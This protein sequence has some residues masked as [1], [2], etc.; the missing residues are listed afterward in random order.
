MTTALPL[1]FAV[2]LQSI[3]EPP[4]AEAT[5]AFRE[6]RYKQAD[7]LMS[8][9]V[10]E[11][12]KAYGQDSPELLPSLSFLGRIRM[13]MGETMRAEL[14]MLRVIAIREK[15]HGPGHP[16]LAPDL[17]ALG[18]FQSTQKRFHAAEPRLARAVEILE[19]FYHALDK[20]L[21]PALD[22]LAIVKI[23]LKYL[24]GAE[25]LLRRAL[26]IRETEFGPHS[27]EVAP[28]LDQLAT[29]LFRLKRY[30]ESEAASE[31][32]LA[33]WIT[34]V[35][36]EHA[37]VAISYDNLAVA[38]AAQQRYEE[39]E[40]NYSRA[41]EIRQEGA[42]RNAHALGLVMAAQGKLNEVEAL[43]ASTLGI[44]DRLP[45]GSPV[46]EVALRAYA[47]ILRKLNKDS[48]AAR[49][50]RRFEP[51]IAWN[52]EGGSLA[53]TEKISNTHFRCHLAGE[54]DQDKRNRQ[55]SWY[56]FRLDHAAGKDTT[57]DLVGLLGEYNYKPNRGAVTRDT[58]P[59]FSYDRVNW[60]HFPATAVEYDEKIP[61]MRLR[62]KPDKHPVWI[63]HVPPYTN[64]DLMLLLRLVRRHP[65]LERRVIGKTA[66]GR[67]LLLLTVTNP[68]VEA[69]SKKV[70]WLMFRQHSWEAGSSWTG[71]G[72]LK[73]LL[74]EDDLAVRMRDTAIF[75]ILPMCDPDG[76][77][78]GGVRFN[79]NGYDLNR[80]WDIVN[81]TL[82][83]EIAAERKAVL[84]WVD[85]GGRL[86]VFLTLHNTETAEYVDGPPQAF[87]DLRDRLFKLLVENTSFHP[88]RP[89]GSAE[90]STTPGK[91][92]RMAVVQGLYRDRKLPAFLMEQRI[93]FNERMKKLP[94]VEDRT[95]FGAQLVIAMWMAVQ[96]KE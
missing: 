62:F 5:K 56:Y 53:R 23:E 46:G 29:V 57:L 32:A 78:R 16:D 10:S 88:S 54:V 25:Q 19:T 45:P 59:V 15:H 36:A 12:E 75:K 58:I 94:S 4:T 2:F 68:A 27:Q 14:P 92:G 48:A 37:L 70:V 22:A 80:N 61:R 24:D 74:S 91:P 52:F 3:P 60:D 73:F 83:P 96:Q 17:I 21:L 81:E 30:Q 50:E 33:I 38:Q 13:A 44:I 71:E 95:R 63:A 18:K 84:D 40:E 9:V 82:M 11:Q 69:R 64:R 47:G 67:D 66:N 26:L 6:G 7:E 20:R 65:H 77:A 43:Y 41:L 35:G 28:T 49:I 51:A 89:P 86:D 42:V 34:V 79:A 85:A 76:V 31:R 87:T 90:V 55:A 1:I 93:A 72:A 8:H 39:A